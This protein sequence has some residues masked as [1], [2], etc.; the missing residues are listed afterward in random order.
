MPKPLVTIEKWAV[1]GSV[2][3]QSFEDLHPG[4]HLIGYVFGHAHLHHSKLVYTSAILSVAVPTVCVRLSF[5]GKA[6]TLRSKA[7]VSR[8]TEI[9][10]CC[11]CCNR[12]GAPAIHWIVS[13]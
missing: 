5:K 7:P 13:L 11:R 1:V 4:S 3:S 10:I 12:A 9:T 6:K 2:I 8:S